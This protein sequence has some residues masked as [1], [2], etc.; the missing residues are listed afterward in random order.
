[1]SFIVGKSRNPVIQAAFALKEADERRMKRIAKTYRAK[2]VVAEPEQKT[3]SQPRAKGG[4][5]SKRKS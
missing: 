3:P 2:P 5:P 4:K 1:M